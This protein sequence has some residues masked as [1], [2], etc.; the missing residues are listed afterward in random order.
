MVDEKVIVYLFYLFFIYSFICLFMSLFF[1]FLQIFEHLVSTMLPD[2]H[3]H[4]KGGEKKHKK[5]KARNKPNE[6]NKSQTKKKKKTNSNKRN[7]T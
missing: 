2:V 4:L 1:F 3:N 7:Q 6:R 5:I